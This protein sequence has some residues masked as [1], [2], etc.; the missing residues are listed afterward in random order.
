MMTPG[1]LRRAMELLWRSPSPCADPLRPACWQADNRR[2]QRLILIDDLDP[3][4]T[5]HDE[6]PPRLP[7]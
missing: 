2:L 3:L 5:D 4:V 1:Q 6:C 7:R